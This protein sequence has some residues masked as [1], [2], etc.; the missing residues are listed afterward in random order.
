MHKASARSFIVFV[1]YS[2]APRF[3]AF[4]QKL[5]DT[6]WSR[7]IALEKSRKHAWL[8]Q[9]PTLHHDVPQLRRLGLLVR[10][11]RYLL[12]GDAALLGYG[13]GSCIRNHS[14]RVHDLALFRRPHR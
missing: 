10:H 4:L 6:K 2:S 8:R 7:L 1:S 12:N 5:V 9:H 14:A 11:D 13:G 3:L